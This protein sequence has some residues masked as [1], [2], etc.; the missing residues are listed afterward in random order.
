MS[1][2][3]LSA[4]G[5]VVAVLVVAAA[6]LWG[7]DGDGSGG[8]ASDARTS[9]PASAASTDRDPGSGLPWVDA[10][11]LP[12][13]AQETLA[14]IDDGGPFPYPG[15]DGSTFRNAEGLLPD[16]PRDYYAEYTVPTP[17][18]TDR[19][20]RR[21]ITGDGGEYYWTADHYAHFERV[22]R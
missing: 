7:G 21:I 19:G 17:G 5:A 8:D 22:R 4:L 16:E 1:R 3:A 6:L 20:A 2:R 13:E 12:D 9:A 18:S 10:A 14:L 11:D 15:K